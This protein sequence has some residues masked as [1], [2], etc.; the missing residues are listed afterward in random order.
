[1][2]RAF[3]R[4]SLCGTVRDLQ[5]GV[6]AGNCGFSGDGDAIEVEAHIGPLLI[7][8]DQNGD[9]SPR[10]ILLVT[11]VLIGGEEEIVSSLLGPLN[12]FAIFSS[13]QPICRA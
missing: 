9:G 13:C 5:E 2:C 3:V 1:M 6:A 4:V 12:Q 8:E 10:D 11:H 7:S